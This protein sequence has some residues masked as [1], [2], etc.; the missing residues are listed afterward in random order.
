[1]PVTAALAAI[2]L[3]G[4]GISQARVPNLQVPAKP[5][6]MG[7][8]GYRDDGVAMFAPANW[9]ETNRTAPLVATIT[10][11][12]AVIALWRYPRSGA[13]LTGPGMTAALDQERSALLAAA[14]KH[15]PDFDLLSSALVTVDGVGAVEL[16]AIERINGRLRRA[17]SEHVYA[18]GAEIVLDEYAPV[19]EFKRV[20]HYVFSPV[21]KGLQLFQ[22]AR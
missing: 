4:C 5:T 1:M 9:T 17:R 3:A 16:D 18:N 8:L 22:S 21:R 12:P 14:K 2:I 15:D 11:G 6:K 7:V 10:S 20:D 13:A 19:P